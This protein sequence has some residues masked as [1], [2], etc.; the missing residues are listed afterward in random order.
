MSQVIFF[1][2]GPLLFLQEKPNYL[3]KIQN[4]EDS[5]RKC[6]FENQNQKVLHFRYKFQQFFFHILF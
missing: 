3:A 6:K 4:F 1:Y 5:F 2:F